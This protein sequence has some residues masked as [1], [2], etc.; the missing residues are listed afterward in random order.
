MCVVGRRNGAQRSQIRENPAFGAEEVCASHGRETFYGCAV[1]NKGNIRWWQGRR[2]KGAEAY[3]TKGTGQV[4]FR[5][6]QIW[7]G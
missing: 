6:W 4:F 2:Q 1:A 3:E 5:R 7:R